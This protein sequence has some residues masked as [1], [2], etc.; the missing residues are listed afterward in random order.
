MNQFRKH[1]L[2]FAYN[3]KKPL[4]NIVEQIEQTL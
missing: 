4:P 2:L 3:K 1:I